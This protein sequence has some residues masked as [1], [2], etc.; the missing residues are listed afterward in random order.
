MAEDTVFVEGDPSRGFQIRIYAGPGGD[1]GVQRRGGGED[2][3][4]Q[5]VSGQLVAAG[6]DP[7]EVLEPAE[8]A[9]DEIALA[10]GAYLIGDQRLASPDRGNDRLDGFLCQQSPQRIGVV[11]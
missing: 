4:S 8:L 1:A 10:I 2:G 5:E 9:L 3:G 7:S 11:G 6:D